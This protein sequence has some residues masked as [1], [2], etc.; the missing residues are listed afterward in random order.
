VG[1]NG[2]LGD[3]KNPFIHKPQT[4]RSALWRVTFLQKSGLKCLNRK[5]IKEL[6]TAERYPNNNNNF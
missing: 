2:I 3:E 5:A 6:L 1:L 4:A